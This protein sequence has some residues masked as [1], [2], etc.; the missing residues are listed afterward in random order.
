MG[1]KKT[2]KSIKY[3]FLS[4]GIE[5][6]SYCIGA[7]IIME[8]FNKVPLYILLFYIMPQILIGGK[9]VIFKNLNTR[10]V[11]NLSA[12][13]ISV[14]LIVLNS[15]KWWFSIIVYKKVNRFTGIIF[16]VI[17]SILVFIPL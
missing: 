6:V 1:D 3:L 4:I 14:G 16:L 17:L 12:I 5:I 15:F 10:T 7:I 11:Y 9:D 8:I 2:M 13:C